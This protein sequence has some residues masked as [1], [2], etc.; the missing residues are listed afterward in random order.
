MKARSTMQCARKKPWNWPHAPLW[1]RKAMSCTKPQGGSKTQNSRSG[2]LARRRLLSISPGDFNNF[3]Q[4]QHNHSVIENTQAQSQDIPRIVWSLRKSSRSRLWW[5][6][7]Q[8]VIEVP[9]SRSLPSPSR[10]SQRKLVVVI[11]SRPQK[12]RKQLRSSPLLSPQ[13]LFH[14]SRDEKTEI[15]M[16]K[17]WEKHR[18]YAVKY[19]VL[20]NLF[21]CDQ[22]STLK[23]KWVWRKKSWTILDHIIL[24]HIALHHIALFSMAAQTK[25]SSGTL[26]AMAP[27]HRAFHR[28][29][30]TCHDHATS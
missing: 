3:Q 11:T 24:I 27:L 7:V 5:F 26:E 2:H 28:S 18:Q 14:C 20:D 29:N 10:S 16:D 1:W 19:W 8:R 12:A 30:W 6:S 22:D 17:R 25:N 15:K 23:M 4:P 13:D 9:F 21:W